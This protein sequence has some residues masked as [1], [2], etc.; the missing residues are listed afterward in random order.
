MK[1]G[2]QR[3][4]VWRRLEQRK[5]VK[6]RKRSKERLRGREAGWRYEGGREGRAV[7]WRKDV[8]RKKI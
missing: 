8:R 5:E 2:V 3:R 4:E 1:E 7:K 6:V